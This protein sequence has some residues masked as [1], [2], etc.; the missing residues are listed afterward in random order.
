MQKDG[1]GQIDHK[2]ESPRHNQILLCQDNTVPLKS[3]ELV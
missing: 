2:V 3:V 1:L